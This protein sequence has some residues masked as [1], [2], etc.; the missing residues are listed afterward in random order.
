M[1][2]KPLDSVT[3]LPLQRDNLIKKFKICYYDEIERIIDGTKFIQGKAICAETHQRRVI[4]LKEELYESARDEY[5]KIYKSAFNGISPQK[6]A[7]IDI[8]DIMLKIT[9]IMKGFMYSTKEYEE[10]RNDIIQAIKVLNYDYS[11]LDNV[12]LNIINIVKPRNGI[13][14]LICLLLQSRLDKGLEI[15]NA[16]IWQD[17]R[18][19]SKE[20]DSIILK[21]TQYEITWE[22]DD[23]EESIYKLESFKKYMSGIRLKLIKFSS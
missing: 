20:H 17:L 19:N 11:V 12:D 21:S 4:I 2:T 5:Y 6:D 16:H 8:T 15:K 18:N 10:D 9:E 22:K 7:I 23:G 14:K 1:S 3:E 13:N